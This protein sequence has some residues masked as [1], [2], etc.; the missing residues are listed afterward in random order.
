[1]N[2]SKEFYFLLGV[3]RAGNTVLGSLI[4]QSPNVALSADSVLMDVIYN[5]NNIKHYNPYFTNFPDHKA[6]DNITKNVFKNYY[7]SY[8]KSKIIDKGCWGSI[9][10]LSALKKIVKKPKFIILYRPVLEC[11]ASYVKSQ[12]N[13]FVDVV[14]SHYMAND[15]LLGLSLHSIENALASGEE[16]LIITYDQFVKNPQDVVNKIFTFIG[17]DTFNVDLDNLSQFNINGMCYDDS[18]LNE[19]LHTIRTNGI[20]KTKTNIEDYLNED[21][22]NK[23]KDRELNL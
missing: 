10:N 7:K 13:P 20:S 21:I 19:P 16:C 22:I 3:P 11:L 2:K 17:E 4:N 12:K 8:K 15:G 9:G 18:V 5:L 14:T 1:M 6:F 23:Y